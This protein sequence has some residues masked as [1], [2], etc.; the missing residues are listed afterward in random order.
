MAVSETMNQQIDIQSIQVGDEIPA[1]RKPPITRLQLALFAGASGD[2][3]PIHVDDEAARGGGLPGVIAHGMLNMAFLGQ[4]LTE[5]VPRRQLRAF[6]T[7]FAAMAFPGDSITCRGVVVAKDVVDGEQRIS[8]ELVAE[9]Q[10]GEALLK[11][12]A[13]VALP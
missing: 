4:L 3:N 7:R 10:N 12:A 9:N 6:S 2:H 5:W 1:L 11:G 8:L 13:E